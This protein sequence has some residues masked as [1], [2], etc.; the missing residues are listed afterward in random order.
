MFG[1]CGANGAAGGGVVCVIFTPFPPSLWKS[2]RSKRLGELFATTT[3]GAGTKLGLVPEHTFSLWNRFDLADG[4]GAGLGVIYQGASYTTISN[5]VTL[6]AFT[7]A[8]AALFYT[9]SDRRTRLSPAAPVRSSSGNDSPVA[10]SPI[11]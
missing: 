2:Q 6:P 1:G 9:F 5:A 4:W 10:G 11:E 3:V 7:R 8:D